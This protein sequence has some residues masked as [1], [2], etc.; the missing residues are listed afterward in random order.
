MFVPRFGQGERIAEQGDLRHVIYG[1]LESDA[2]VASV[3]V[4][5][6]ISLFVLRPSVGETDESLHGRKVTSFT[7]NFCPET[8][9]LRYELDEGYLL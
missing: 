4:V 8:S 3:Q 7:H 2:T 9:P 6:I 1:R 5:G